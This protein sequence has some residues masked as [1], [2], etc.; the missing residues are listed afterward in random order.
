VRQQAIAGP[1]HPA[2][3]FAGE[4]LQHSCHHTPVSMQQ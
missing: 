1:Q 2:A 3:V 4:A